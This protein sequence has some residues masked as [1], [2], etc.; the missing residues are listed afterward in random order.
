MSADATLLAGFLRNFLS[1]TMLRSDIVEVF[2]ALL[3]DTLPP[4]PEQLRPNLEVSRHSRQRLPLPDPPYG[5]DLE[6]SAETS[7]PITCLFHETLSEILS[8]SQ[9][10]GLI[11][12]VHSSPVSL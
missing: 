5:R 9:N 3:D 2:F 1:P 8:F 12:G 7:P 11:F 10:R 4:P 6:L